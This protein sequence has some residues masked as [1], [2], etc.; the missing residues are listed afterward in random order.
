VLGLI[1]AMVALAAT[2]AI[3][4]R[5]AA[6]R[7]WGRQAYTRSRMDERNHPCER[8]NQMTGPDGARNARSMAAREYALVVEGELSDELCLAF[9]G[10][11]LTRTKGKTVLVGNVRDQAELHGLFQRVSN[12]GLTLL[13]ATT[14]DED[15]TR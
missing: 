13:S 4:A 12:L 14:T 11:T 6:A 8:I 1:A 5:S 9:S 7:E 2:A 10:M 3:P 15:G